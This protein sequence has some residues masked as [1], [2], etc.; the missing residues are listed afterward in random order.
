M[1][2]RGLGEGQARRVLVLASGRGG[3]VCAQCQVCAGH[4]DRVGGGAAF[5][6][7]QVP[8]SFKG[9]AAWKRIK[10]HRECRSVLPRQCRVLQWGRMLHATRASC[11]R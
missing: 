10:L 6:N 3:A 4:G 7:A 5:A 8:Y 1:G 2:S 11:T 9:C